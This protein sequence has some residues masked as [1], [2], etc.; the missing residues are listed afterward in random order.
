MIIRSRNN[1]TDIAQN[2][3]VSNAVVAGTNVIPWK[4]ASGFSAS[5]AIQLGQTGE[6]QSE[7]VV[8]SA[9]TPA[10]TA[11]TIA[12]SL[13]YPHPSD[14]PIYA[15][16]YD[17]VVFER[18]T[19]GTA[20]TA[21]PITNGTIT[22]QADSPFTQFDDTTGAAT[23]AYRTYFRSSVL[24]IN[25]S[26]SDW[27]TPSGFSFYSLANLR[28]RAKERLWNGSYLSDDFLTSGINEWKDEMTNAIISINEE[29]ALGTVDIPFGTAGLGTI[30]TTDFK[31]VKRIWVTFNGNDYWKSNNIDSNFFSPQDV[32]PAR[33]PSHYYQGDT[34]IG[35]K[36][37][38][39][40]GTARLEFYRFG[41]TMVNDTDELP[42]PFRSY[43]K[44][45]IDYLESLALKKD[46]KY[47]EA[48]A[49]LS[50]ARDG[51]DRFMAEMTPRDKSGP[52]MVDLVE[53]ISGND[54]LYF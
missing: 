15:T 51:K 18:S 40:A 45:F 52:Q 54:N 27:I 17:Q 39:Q 2:T 12:G 31:Q 6:E 49:P 21:L 53:G 44:S 34:I 16:K 26:E 29:Y 38:G 50:E 9:S 4:N 35:I 24:A 41:T 23:Y 11:G 42:L 19:T 5:W 48:N 43:T 25:S 28:T 32:F 20:G 3:F 30:T 46:G 10:G 14:T 8:L 37:D 1:I 22:I 7:V 33:N 36:P 47:T 13:L